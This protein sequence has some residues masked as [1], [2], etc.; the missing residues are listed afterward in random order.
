[1]GKEVYFGV[2][3]RMEMVGVNIELEGA[4]MSLQWWQLRLFYR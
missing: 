4:C 3:K 1:M 2:A